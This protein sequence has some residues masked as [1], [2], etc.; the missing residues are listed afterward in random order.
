MNLPSLPTDSL[1]KF[2]AMTG[3]IL[4]LFFSYKFI[5]EQAEYSKLSIDFSKGNL[6][7]EHIMPQTLTDEWKTMLGPNWAETHKK[8]LH[9]SGNWLLKKIRG[10]LAVMANRRAYDRERI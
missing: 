5:D 6:S 10:L 8:Y 4:V 1:Y 7:I 9:T 2:V 3:L